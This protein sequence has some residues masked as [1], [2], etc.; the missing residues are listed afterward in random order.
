MSKYKKLSLSQCSTTPV[1]QFLRMYG[2]RDCLNVSPRGEPVV[3]WVFVWDCTSPPRVT[4]ERHYSPLTVP[5]RVVGR[6]LSSYVTLTK[7]GTIL[8]IRKFNRSKDEKL[9]HTI[10]HRRCSLK[11][12][13]KSLL[14]TYSKEGYTDFW[15]FPYQLS[16][17][18]T[19]N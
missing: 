11:V 9:W 13:V 5:K 2:V 14:V 3:S 19:R 17:T 6:L 15:G 12:N 7:R 10:F 8:S 16:T 4:D 1:V 18:M